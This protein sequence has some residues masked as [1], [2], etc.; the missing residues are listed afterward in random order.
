LTVELTARALPNWRQR[1]P[2]SGVVPAANATSRRQMV[3]VDLENPPANLLPKMAIAAELQLPAAQNSFVVPRDALVQRDDNWFVYTVA[4][5]KA[6]EIKVQLVVDMGET[7]AISGA[8]LR[9]GQPVVVRGGEALM[10][11][12]PVQVAEQNPKES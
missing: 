2:I 1:A 3:R 7:V 10:N 4:N 5:G 8:Q 9:S 11:G 6:A 12:A